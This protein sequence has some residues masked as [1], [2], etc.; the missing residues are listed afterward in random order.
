MPSINIKKTK[1]NQAF[2]CHFPK[3]IME[4]TKKEE[5]KES[6]EN[7]LEIGEYQIDGPENGNITFDKMTLIATSGAK[8]IWKVKSM[9]NKEII[10]EIIK[11][12]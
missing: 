2:K 5:Q 6:K 11:F 10:F 7:V 9:T 8:R 12:G 1:N 4:E 3:N